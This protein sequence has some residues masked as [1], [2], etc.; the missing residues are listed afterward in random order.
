MTQIARRAALKLATTVLA[1]PSLSRYAHAAEITW[2]VGHVAPKDTPLHQHLMEASDAIAKRSD[3]KMELI[4]IGEGKAGIQSGLLN[5]VRQGGLEMTVAT[6]TQLFPKLPMCSIPL[7]GFVFGSYASVWPAM[8]GDLGQ[9]IR[10]QIQAQLGLEI[11]EKIWDF[12]F[13]HITTTDRLISNASDIAGLKIRTQIDADQMDMFRSLAATPVVITLSYLRMALEHRQ[14]D[15]QEGMLPLV[16]YARLNEVQNRCA[17]TYHG[18]DGLWLCI[19][20]DAWRKL[21]ERLQ[22]IV[23]NTLNGSAL[24]QREDS[25]K[26]EDSIRASLSDGGMKFN[27]VDQASFREMLRRQGYY[28]RNRT[29]LGEQLWEVVQKATGLSA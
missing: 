29:K 20:S 28:A 14:I 8:D 7:M 17:L 1:A 13:R 26:M 25:A 12:G 21:P 6:C 11:L 22:R 5:Q 19:N 9:M 27:E 16:Q 3:G 10:S 15:G 4:V 2:R 24:R 18:W 23:V